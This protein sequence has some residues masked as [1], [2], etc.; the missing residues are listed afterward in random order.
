M[1]P[2]MARR[3]RVLVTAVGLVA[4]TL[5]GAA[6]AGACSCAE[7]DVRAALRRADGAFVGTFVDRAEIDDQRAA[8]TFRVETVIK[9]G[10]GPTAVVRTNAYGAS[11]GLEFFGEPR[12]GL[13]LER[14]DDGVW[15]SSLC[16]MVEPSALL[17]IEGARAPDPSIAPVSAGRSFGTTVL[18]VVLGAVA[19]L[20][21]LAWAT[22]GRGDTVG[23][24]GPS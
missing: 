11:C 7:V 1:G 18:L 12:T 20:A 5:I 15:E 17:A 4:M 2:T 24:S 22:R 6:P 3:L 19:G 13:F 21:V 14:A 10:F 9:G 23:P 16:S 8:M